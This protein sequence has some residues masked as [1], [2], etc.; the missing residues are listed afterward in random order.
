MAKKSAFSISEV[1]G[2]GWKTSINNIWFFIPMLL[3][4]LVINIVL[5]YAV[6]AFT[7][8]MN[9]SF[10]GIFN[11]VVS[12]ASWILGIEFG[13]AQLVL[14]LKFVDRK[15]PALEELFSYFNVYFLW[16]YLAISL[17]YGLLIAVGLVLFIVPG[18]YFA[19]KYWFALYIFID[20]RKGIM[21]SFTQSAKLTEGIKLKLFLL[22]ILQQLII[23][24]G[25]LALL[26]GLFVA[27]PINALSDFYLYRKLEQ[28][29]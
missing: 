24:A 19:T 1:L 20:K 22:G 16:G 29:A 28:K 6:G 23:A 26:V 4:P 14:Y 7:A 15:K 10:K 5:S 13:F 2:Y 9:D 11:I 8:G 3:I 25:L 27:I 17:V 18:I 21:E 12:L